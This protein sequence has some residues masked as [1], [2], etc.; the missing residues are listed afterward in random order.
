MRNELIA[1]ACAVMTA[2]IFATA[3][4]AE[5]GPKVSSEHY[6][7]NVSATVPSNSS[8]AAMMGPKV[9]GDD[10][11]HTAPADYVGGR[12]A[13]GAP[14]YVY[15]QGYDPSGKWHGHWVLVR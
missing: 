12:A 14:H 13:A 8:A 11:V 1:A 10:H 6:A 5:E 2:A 3:A 15:Q 4:L 9:S 7:P